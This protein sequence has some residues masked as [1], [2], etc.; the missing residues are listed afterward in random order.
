LYTISEDGRLFRLRV[1]KK[2]F[3]SE[4]L[5]KLGQPFQQ[6]EVRVEGLSMSPE[7]LL[8]A[9]VVFRF[10]LSEESVLYHIDPRSGAAMRIG[11]ILPAEV[12]GLDF[13]PEDRLYG[14]LS[15]CRHSSLTG[16]TQ[17][18]EIDR[19]TGQAHSTKTEVVHRRLDALAIGKNGRAIISN[20]WSGLY[21]VGLKPRSGSVPFLSDEEF[22]TQM[23]N[24]R[25]EGL[26]YGQG[27]VLFA[28]S[29][30]CRQSAGSLVRLDPKTGK[31]QHIADLNFDAKNLAANREGL[32]PPGPAVAERT[33]P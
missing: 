19:R 7:G 27:G 14:V 11:Q 2:S 9:S 31:F 26:C 5:V 17:L 22:C 21:Q 29:H 8:Y 25:L 4:E 32:S 3:E 10:P 15:S 12:T 33:R 30:S 20:T 6:P 23:G 16:D 13:G 28:I 1:G 24:A 18:I